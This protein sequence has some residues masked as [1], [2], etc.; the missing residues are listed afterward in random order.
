MIQ[1]N[2]CSRT[3]DILD[4]LRL[5]FRDT[6]CMGDLCRNILPQ[7]EISHSK[8]EQDA[9]IGRFGIH[10]NSTSNMREFKIT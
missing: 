7:Q 10:N 5:E 8:S 9:L 1:D 4:I 3:A 6:R 2:G